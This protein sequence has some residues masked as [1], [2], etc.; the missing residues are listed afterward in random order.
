VIFV[1]YSNAGPANSLAG[2]V[3]FCATESAVR[4]TV[5]WKRIGICLSVVALLLVA[6]GCGGER[7]PGKYKNQDKPKTTEEQ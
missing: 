4:G 6:S 5:M 7:E 3:F 1:S 2:L